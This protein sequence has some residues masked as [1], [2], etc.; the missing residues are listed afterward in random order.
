[1]WLASGQLTA[2]EAAALAARRDNIKSAIERQQQFESELRAITTATDAAK[3]KSLIEHF[4]SKWDGVISEQLHAKLAAVWRSANSSLIKADGQ[5]RAYQ[6]A[7]AAQTAP[8]VQA[9]TAQLV[10]TVPAQ[11]GILGWLGQ[12]VSAGLGWLNQNVSNITGGTWLASNWA[13]GRST[14]TALSTGYYRNPW[15][16]LVSSFTGWLDGIGRDF[17]KMG[18]PNSIA[19][20][21]VSGIAGLIHFVAADILYGIY[22]ATILAADGLA[23]PQNFIDPSS[24]EWTE[25]GNFFEAGAA[26]RNWFSAGLAGLK[27]DWDRNPCF[28]LGQFVGA[29]LAGGAARSF[30]GEIGGVKVRITGSQIRALKGLGIAEIDA[31]IA[32]LERTTNPTT[33]AGIIGELNAIY[34][35]YV[36][37]EKIISI[38]GGKYYDFKIER[39]GQIV[40]VEI[41]N[42][43]WEKL[44]PEALRSEIGKL[45]NQK[46]VA[47][48]KGEEFELRSFHPIPEALRRVLEEK[49]IDYKVI[50]G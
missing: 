2:A 4:R 39:S 47:Y 41:K 7:L 16:N 31:K 37:G 29:V 49:G 38:E 15:V 13:T 20:G 32:E 50:G 11:S 43:H 46:K 34:D 21:M 18:G 23:H 40:N 48:A 17:A 44:N 6:A 45:V 28:V 14:A 22:A 10:T 26:L 5:R 33:R 3:A 30:V 42:V 36:R 35:S 12:Q 8:Q 24:E 19:G 9:Q 1:R 27:E 25:R